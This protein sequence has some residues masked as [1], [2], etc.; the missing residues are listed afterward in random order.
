VHEVAALDT[1]ALSLSQHPRA[2]FV[3]VLPALTKRDFEVVWATL[4][5]ARCAAPSVRT[6]VG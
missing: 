3:V 2:Y 1:L 6:C 4:S 5:G